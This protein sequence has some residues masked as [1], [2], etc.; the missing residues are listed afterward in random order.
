VTDAV[1]EASEAAVIDPAD[2]PE[3]SQKIRD[4][5]RNPFCKAHK[6]CVECKRYKE[7][8]NGFRPRQNYCEKHKKHK[9]KNL[10]EDPLYV[11]ACPGCQL[12]R[13]SADR[14]P[15][16]VP[17]DR[18]RGRSGKAKK[19]QS[20]KRHKKR[21]KR[22]RPKKA[23]K[24]KAPKK[25]APKKK[26]PRGRLGKGRPT[27]KARPDWSKRLRLLRMQNGLSQLALAEKLQVSNRRVCSWELGEGEPS[28]E[29]QHALRKVLGWS[30]DQPAESADEISEDTPLGAWLKRERGRSGL[31]VGELADKARVL[32]FTI[33]GIESGVSANPPETELRKLQK[34]LGKIPRG[35]VDL[36]PKLLGYEIHDFDPRSND[37]PAVKGV[38]LLRDK[39]YRDRFAYIG[40]GAKGMGTIVPRINDHR[41]KTWFEPTV[42]MA[43]Y[44]KIPDP[45][46]ALRVERLLI[47]ACRPRYNQRG[48]PADPYRE[49][50]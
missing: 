31:T 42:G 38:Y 44:I 35:I 7:R 2:C 21:P 17:C 12:V 4:G 46:E 49:D 34:V 24:K 13:S 25:K 32:A 11:T 27:N 9:K 47:W 16:C 43:H 33:E 15:R 5:H 37:L 3:C 39:H 10:K 50:E 26:A 45:A 40:K 6:R 18:A 8:V 14:Q 20:K 30:L 48:L 41:E 36:S 1:A 19:A 29:Q 28:Q 23:P 22:A